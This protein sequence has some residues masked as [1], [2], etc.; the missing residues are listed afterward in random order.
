MRSRLK[1]T[2]FN[3]SMWVV[4]VHGFFA[5]LWAL[6]FQRKAR[7][8]Y[9]TDWF[10]PSV[11]IEKVTYQHTK[12]H[13]SMQQ[14]IVNSNRNQ[15]QTIYLCCVWSLLEPHPSKAVEG[16]SRNAKIKIAHGGSHFCLFS[17]VP[18]AY[19]YIGILGSPAVLQSSFYHT[20]HAFL[21]HFVYS[22]FVIQY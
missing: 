18:H 3:F 14:V 20:P 13:I 6:G 15:N 12:R 16:T 4:V 11:Y 1:W 7:H 19:A 21:V 22:P 2:Y 5:E 10:T 17:L 9:R 8:N